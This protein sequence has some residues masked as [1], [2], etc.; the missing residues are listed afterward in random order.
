MERMSLGTS[1]AEVEIFA[2]LFGPV[3]PTYLH[4][5]LL[6]LNTQPLPPLQ[7]PQQTIYSMHPMMDSKICYSITSARWLATKKEAAARTTAMPFTMAIR[8]PPMAPMMPSQQEAIA[9]TMDPCRTQGSQQ[10]EQQGATHVK[11]VP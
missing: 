7:N 10:F 11:N 9:E 4:T 8:N 3:L 1:S 5:Y 6:H 2:S